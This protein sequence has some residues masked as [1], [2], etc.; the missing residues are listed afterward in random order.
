M[1][2]STSSD[3]QNAD[4]HCPEATANLRPAGDV[5]VKYFMPDFTCSLDYSLSVTLL[6]LA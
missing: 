2:I 4:A 5:C 1:Q 3:L 6:A